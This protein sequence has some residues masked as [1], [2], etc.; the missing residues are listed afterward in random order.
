MH[1]SAAILI[2]GDARRLQGAFKPGLRVGHQTILHRQLDALR[3]SGIDEVMVIGRGGESIP[4]GVRWVPDVIAQCGP[5]GG[6]YSALLAA[7]TPIVIVLA[8]DLPF[9][10]PELIRR[11]ALLGP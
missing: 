5:L 4:A 7:T 10:Q 9:V 8:G 2:G 11:L 3:A 6:I 1:T